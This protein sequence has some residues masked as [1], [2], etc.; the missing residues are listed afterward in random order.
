MDFFAGCVFVVNQ[1]IKRNEKKKCETSRG[2]KTK[3]GFFFYS[4]ALRQFHNC[5]T[6]GDCDLVY[7]SAVG[8]WFFTRD[9]RGQHRA[10]L[11]ITT[12]NIAG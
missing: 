12:R 3:M 6:V 10:G 4:Q 1:A 2:K 7:S 5:G 11:Q 8:D 9:G